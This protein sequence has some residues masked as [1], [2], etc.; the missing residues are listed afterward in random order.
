MFF[1]TCFGAKDDWFGEVSTLSQEE[2]IELFPNKKILHR[3]ETFQ[4]GKTYAGDTKFW[5]TN[6]FVIKN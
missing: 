6:T 1:F 5:H 4:Y 2:I 3:S